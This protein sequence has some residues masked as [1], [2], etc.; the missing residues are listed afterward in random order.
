MQVVK[1]PLIVALTAAAFLTAACSRA[2]ENKEAIRQGVMD[3]LQRNTGLDMNAMTVDVTDVKY[4]GNEAD[5]TVSFKPKNMPGQGMSM[6]YTLAQKDGKWTVQGKAGGG[7]GEVH[8]G[9]G[10]PGGG[11]APG[12]GAMGGGAM[13]PGHPPMGGGTMGSG[14]SGGGAM[15]PGHPPV[16]AA[17]PRTGSNK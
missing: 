16:G 15:P 5:A 11:A 7:G 17:N 10:T 1:L 8:P 3:H 14:A 13:P 12:G 9:A 2:P 6:R 4:R